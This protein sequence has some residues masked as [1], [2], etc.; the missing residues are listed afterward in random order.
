MNLGRWERL[1]DVALRFRFAYRL[2]HYN[3]RGAR[4]ACTLQEHPQH[5]VP[6][7]ARGRFRRADYNIAQRDAS[8]GSEW[9]VVLGKPVASG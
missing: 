8:T 9:Q 3:L 7:S 1:F 4:A 6:E 2:E 5:Q